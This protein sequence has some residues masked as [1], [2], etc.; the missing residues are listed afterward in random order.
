VVARTGFSQLQ[1]R[2][3]FTVALLAGRSTART[4]HPS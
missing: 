3:G 4:A 1:N 2:A